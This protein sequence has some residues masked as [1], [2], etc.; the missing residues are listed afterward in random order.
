M[1]FLQVMFQFNTKVYDNTEAFKHLEQA[2]LQ[3]DFL[4]ARVIEIIKRKN[5]DNCN[6]IT[7]GRSSQNDIILYNNIVSKSHAFLY[8]HQDCR[9][10][11]VTDLESTNNSYINDEKI[12]PYKLY[13]LTD[14]DEI[15][16]GPQTKVIYLTSRAFYDFIL[17]L[18][19][20]SC[21]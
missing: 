11:Y 7:I 2:D 15:S 21:S 18:K 5:S 12:V 10:I 8:C 4:E 1:D 13:Q 14:G 20:S 19:Q 3:T 17:S 9:A 6:I 16:F